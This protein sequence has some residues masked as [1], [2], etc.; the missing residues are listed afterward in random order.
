MAEQPTT[1]EE[2][3]KTFKEIS[4]NFGNKENRFKYAS[5]MYTQLIP[6]IV[7]SVYFPLPF[8]IYLA[9]LVLS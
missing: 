2:A 1:I 7:V 6:I 4:S 5:P 9:L 3:L 8:S